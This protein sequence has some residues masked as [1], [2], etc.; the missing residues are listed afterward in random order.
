[1]DLETSLGIVTEQTAQMLRADAC[2][3]YL[4]R[5]NLLSLVAQFGEASNQPA[6][7]LTELHQWGRDNQQFLAVPIHSLDGF[8]LGSLMLTRYQ[9]G[10]AGGQEFTAFEGEQL[11]SLAKLAASF[12]TQ[13]ETQQSGEKRETQWRSLAEHAPGLFWMSKDGKIK[14][15]SREAR[16][17]GLQLGSDARIAET[18]WPG[19]SALIDRVLAGET[20]SANNPNNFENTH[21]NSGSRQLLQ[22]SPLPDGGAIGVLLNA[23]A[24]ANGLMFD[25]LPFGVVVSML[26]G[27]PL[28]MN[29][30][31]RDVVADTALFGSTVLGGPNQWDA[32]ASHESVMP[33]E[34]PMLLEL[35]T[36][37]RQQYKAV[38]L[39]KDAKPY[40]ATVM[41][42]PGEPDKLLHLI[43]LPAQDGDASSSQRS[44]IEER[45]NLARE[46][47]DGIGKDLYG[48]AMLLDGAARRANA[49]E[50]PTAISLSAD[51]NSFAKETRDM[52]NRARA[53]I[54]NM[55][56]RETNL[57]DEL[58]ELIGKAERESNLR[59]RLE[60]DEPLPKLAPERRFELLRIA[61]EA[62]RNATSHARAT[63]ILVRLVRAPNGLKLEVE[64]DGQGLPTVLP[65]GHYGLAG[66]RE[67]AEQLGGSL[68]V[69]SARGG[70]RIVVELPAA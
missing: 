2:A 17:A 32:R 57:L 46:L 29:Q 51:L 44:R 58:R 43:N 25:R 41:L 56:K 26:N 21:K 10:L 39:G 40:D 36:H 16:A 6:P 69:S 5:G 12:L 64:D 68:S 35:C 13:F 27:E 34:W 18:E 31:A 1:M 45:M 54:A 42:L 24:E 38:R 59:F 61:Q 28:M 60:H 23:V 15:A 53:L 33:P 3:M 22:L 37:A 50:S 8:N 63:Q 7:M 55:R 9:T 67:R 66:M 65:Q 4:L 52:A 11:K 14:F 20:L 30:H 62:I 48:L 70:T 19:W 47:H 49:I